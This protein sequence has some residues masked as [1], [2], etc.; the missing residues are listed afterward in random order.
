MKSLSKSATNGKK[1]DEAES[2][3]KH[4]L[5]SQSKA[6]PQNSK[7]LRKPQHTKDSDESRKDSSKRLPPP[8]KKQLERRVVTLNEE[9]NDEQETTITNAAT[10]RKAT[11]QAAKH[12]KK[13]RK[14]SDL[15]DEDDVDF[16][17]SEDSVE[18]DS[19]DES[20][21]DDDQLTR[22]ENRMQRECVRFF[23]TASHDELLLAP[24]MNG[25][26]AEF[27]L[28]NR[29]FDTFQE[30][31][32]T[33]PLQRGRKSLL[34]FC[35]EYLENRDVLNLILNDCKGDSAKVAAEFKYYRDS[36]N[37]P[38]LLDKSMSLH[39]YQK[40]GLNWLVMMHEKKLNCILGDEMGLGKTIQIVAFLA[41]LKEKKVD[42][43]LSTYSMVVSKSDDKNFF[44]N[45][46]INYVV[47]DEGHMLKNCST[48]R[49]KSLM[50]IK[51]SRK[52]LL[53]GTPLQ[54][55]LTELISLMYFVM[56]KIFDRY[57]DNMAQLLS[58]FKPQKGSAIEG[59][60]ALYQ[61]D[62]IEQAKAIL[63]PYILRRLKHQVLNQLPKKTEEVATINMEAEQA[64]IYDYQLELLQMAGD[65]SSTASSSVI[66]LRQAA[67]HPL[68][69]RRIFD[70]DTCAEVAKKLVRQE[71][72][73]A[74]KRAEHV[75]EDL[76]CLSDYQIHKI[77]KKFPSTSKFC[78]DDSVAIESGKCKFLDQRL[79]LIK[80][81]GDKVLIF[82]QF[83]Q[84][85]DILEVYLRVRGHSFC[86]MD[87]ST[88]V[89]ERQANHI[90]IH[91]IDFNPYNDKQAEDRC[92]R[93]GQEKPVHVVR[94]ISKGT[95]EEGIARLAK[96]KLQLEKEMI[97]LATNKEGESETELEAD[98]L[99]ELM[100]QV[101]Q[102]KSEHHQRNKEAAG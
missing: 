26:L 28:A 48:E 29:P 38:D 23:N 73:Y 39:N 60:Q 71:K 59:T 95:I 55:N 30:L 98:V 37:I 84:M 47:Y 74:K 88:P 82:S 92:H 4:K 67:N 12:R 69:T 86:R 33:L 31:E 19:E 79:P 64:D 51:S 5:S 62:R 25:K 46:K 49:Y 7:V 85:L 16:N 100:K 18:S 96:R 93:M 1:Q 70:D 72:E 65:S 66:R 97:P 81:K 9:S 57:C 63:E 78:I 34:E 54:N 77:C 76:L 8:P 80:T 58:H 90:F 68:L 36:Q 43:L 50:K 102:V 21:S 27:L 6:M 40:E 101:V 17:A 61:Q 3:R 75:A 14:L 99:A 32:E 94:M 42:V 35:M 24:R 41:W 89:M 87:G 13:N 45:F 52:I 20:D 10:L 15:N 56:R 2:V 53:T 44:K 22:S 11:K 83:T 91:D